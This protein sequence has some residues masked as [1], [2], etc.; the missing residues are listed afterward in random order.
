MRFKGKVVLITAV[1]NGIGRATANIMAAEGAIVVGIDNHQER[2]DTA[3]NALTAAGG[4]FVVVL[5]LMP[6]PML[7]LA[8]LTMVVDDIS[9]G[10]G[11]AG[12]GAGAS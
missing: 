11:D 10:G 9:D 1:A 4:V 6:E 5:A 7:M 2:L 8:V 3:M 12:A